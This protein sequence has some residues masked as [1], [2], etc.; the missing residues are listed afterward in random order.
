MRQIVDLA[1]PLEGLVRQDS[2]HAAGVVIGDRPLTEY[3]PLQQKGADQEVVTQFPMGDVEA[4][5]LLK[6]D[7][8]GLRNLDVID[9]AVELIDGDLDMRTLPLDDPKTYEMLRAGESTGVFQFESSGMREALRQVKPT[10]FEDLIALVA[11][12][13]PG[14]MGYIPVYAKRKAGGEQVTFLDERLEADHRA[15]VRHLH[16]PGAVHGDRQAARRLLARR[17]GRSPQGDRQ[18]DP[19]ADGVPQGQVPRGLRGERASRRRWRPS[20]GRTWSRRRTTPSTSRTPP[21]TR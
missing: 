21:A 5:G 18:E 13:R 19:Q 4:L 11:L 16:L 7:F 8:L 17:G 9:K 6:M 3:V 20:S 2:I 15:D 12:Y 14:P 1:R 10:E